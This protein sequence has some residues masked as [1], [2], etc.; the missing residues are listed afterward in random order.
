MIVTG[1]CAAEGW[2]SPARSS[3]RKRR[4]SRRQRAGGGGRHGIESLRPPTTRI[5]LNPRT[6]HRLPCFRGIA[7]HFSC[8]SLGKGDVALPVRARNLNQH[9]LGGPS[10]I[11]D[12][13]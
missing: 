12:S 2:L 9:S 6:I 7:K 10:R 5:R 3:T 1:T 13:K 4:G 11:P 8:L